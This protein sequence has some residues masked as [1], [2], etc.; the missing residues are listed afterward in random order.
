MMSVHLAAARATAALPTLTP[1]HP[2]GAGLRMA[3]ADKPAMRI[4][5]DPRLATALASAVLIGL[6]PSRALAQDEAALRSYFEGRRVTVTI[7]MPG[8]SDGV[9]IQVDSPRPLDYQRYGDR[10]KADGAAI[11]A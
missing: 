11:R 10:L 1:K 5:A 3:G 9:D 4:T 7:D 8:T 6:Y 2:P